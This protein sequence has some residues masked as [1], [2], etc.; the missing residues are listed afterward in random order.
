MIKTLATVAI[1]LGVLTDTVQAAGTAA[2][3]RRTPVER[4]NADDYALM[5]ARVRE[6]LDAEQDGETLE[7]RNDKTRASGSVT[8][9]NRLVWEGLNCRRLR[10]ANAVPG[11]SAQGVFKF[12]EKPAGRWRLVGPDGP[13]H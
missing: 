12:C 10:I 3:L 9:V 6:A 8:P 7:W 11:N 13:Q 1:L 5:K 4:F 2:A